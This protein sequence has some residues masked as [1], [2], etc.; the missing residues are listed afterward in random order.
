M[1]VLLEMDIDRLVNMH[2]A[3]EIRDLM[4]GYSSVSI[5]FNTKTLLSVDPDELDRPLYEETDL[6]IENIDTISAALREIRNGFRPLVLNM[7]N[8]KH[9]GGGF[10]SGAKAQEEDLFRCTNLSGTLKE[11]LYPM[12]FNEII[13]TPKAYIL[14]DSEYKDLDVPVEVSFVTVAAHNNPFTRYDGTLPP[15]V[16]HETLNKIKMIYQL[17]LLQRHDCL[18]LGALGCGAFNNPPREI[19]EMFCRV[20]GDYAQKFKKVIF[21]IMCDDHN[22]NCSTFQKAFLEAYS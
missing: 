21:P 12:L 6:E 20:T 19:A 16:Y 2:R 14:R 5:K 1:T 7:A 9:P 13:Y 3:Q 17:G 8:A 10:L 4:T 11:T 18:I 22:D 15:Y